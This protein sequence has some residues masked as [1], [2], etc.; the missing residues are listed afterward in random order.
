M[1][2]RYRLTITESGS[3]DN[4][5]NILETR[6]QE[7]ENMRSGKSTVGKIFSQH[8]THIYGVLTM[9]DS[10]L[11]LL[12]SLLNK[13]KDNY[14]FELTVLAGK[15]NKSTRFVP[16]CFPWAQILGIPDISERGSACGAE[17]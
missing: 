13:S 7:D 10:R 4:N 11:G 1:A 6:S 12:D 3:R 8:S 17:T 14:S 2:V 15:A 16:E 9:S 5:N